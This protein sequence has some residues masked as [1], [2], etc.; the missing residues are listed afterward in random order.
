MQVEVS[1]IEGELQRAQKLGEEL[2]QLASRALADLDARV[3]LVRLL[4]LT[5]T[6]AREDAEK[7]KGEQAEQ[8]LVD[9]E[10]AGSR[11]AAG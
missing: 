10:P 5:E 1:F 6:Q 3:I 9:G 4:D 11:A 8:R 7:A 2:Q